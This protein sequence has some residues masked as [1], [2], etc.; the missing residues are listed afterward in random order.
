MN[1]HSGSRKTGRLESVVSV[2]FTEREL[3]QVRIAA[4]DQTVSQFIRDAV[5]TSLTRQEHP[6]V[7]AVASQS[8]ASPLILNSGSDVFSD[9][10]P[11][12]L[13]ISSSRA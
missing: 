1:D 4:A 6:R 9:A 13:E 7:Q 5:L 11:Y 3:E 8:W 2:R 10:A 12:Q